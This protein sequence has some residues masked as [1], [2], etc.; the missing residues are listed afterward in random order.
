MRKTVLLTGAS[1]GLGLALARKLIAAD[2]YRVVLTA[3]AES[4]PRFSSEGIRESEHCLVRPLDVL[5]PEEREA[6]VREL[7]ERFERVDV[8]I[9]NAGFSFRAVLEHVQ[10]S[11]YV[12]QMGTNFEAAIALIRLVLPGMR[13]ARAG[14][15][16]NVSS[17]GGMMAMPTMAIYSASKFALEGA[18]EALYYE[19]RPWNIRVTL[20]EP[21]FIHSDSFT[22]VQFTTLSAE[23]LND[24]SEPYFGHYHFMGR[25]IATLMKRSPASPDKI[26]K[27]IL[28]VI[29]SSRPPL[30]VAATPDAILFSLMRRL[31]PQR[32]YHEILY[33]MLPHVRCWGNPARLRRICAADLARF[34]EKQNEE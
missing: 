26:S 28:R 33:R 7:T 6:L 5:I 8:L 21:G 15:I 16:I 29:E 14:R 27:K 12:R 22:K 34:A 30:R 24:V 31:I 23:S 20:I 19:V 18:S 9:N 13:T 25:F 4:L 32:L 10:T 1:A 3:R 11:E 17:V 2:K